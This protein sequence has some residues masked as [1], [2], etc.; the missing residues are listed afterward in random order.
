MLQSDGRTDAGF[1]A[2]GTYVADNAYRFPAG[3]LFLART[4]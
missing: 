2:Y 3:A 4:D 1:A